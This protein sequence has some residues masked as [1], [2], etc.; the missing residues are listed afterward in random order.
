MYLVLCTCVM[1]YI[2]F[3]H[4]DHWMEKII[5]IRYTIYEFY[6]KSNFT[7]I[8]P[9]TEFVRNMHHHRPHKNSMNRSL[10]KLINILVTYGRSSMF[11]RHPMHLSTPLPTKRSSVQIT[12]C[13]QLYWTGEVINGFFLKLICRSGHEDRYFFLKMNTPKSEKKNLFNTPLPLDIMST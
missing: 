6:F 7:T 4:S 12:D 3:L 10:W 8:I 2:I 11:I 13:H 9:F 5:I 1:L